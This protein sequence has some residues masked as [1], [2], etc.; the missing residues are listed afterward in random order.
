MTTQTEPQAISTGRMPFRLSVAQYL[1]MIGL[2]FFPDDARVELLG[3]LLVR[4]MTKYPPHNFTVGRLGRLLPGL[5]PAPWIVDVERPVELGRFWRPEPDLVIL[6]G[7]DDLYRGRTPGLGDLGLL[8]EV[9]DSS[10]ATDRGAKWR[11][12]AS[13]G[14]P[15]YWIVDL[16]R[17]QVEVFGEPEGR[18]RSAV[19]RQSAVFGEG[20]EVP[21]VLDGS[22]IGR[23]AV[24]SILP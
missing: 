1:R 3:G 22:E 23:I 10:Y 18:G 2:G 7:P 5:L 20:A 17:R 19:Y 24:G 14:V 21:V 13:T 4:K 16:A 8:I 9:A 6:R 12:Y 11:G 15:A